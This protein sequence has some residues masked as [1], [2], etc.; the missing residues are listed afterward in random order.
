MGRPRVGDGGRVVPK[1]GVPRDEDTEEGVRGVS[2]S[3]EGSWWC[4]Y[5]DPVHVLVLIIR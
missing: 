1:F 4:K 5:L 3:D 2:R